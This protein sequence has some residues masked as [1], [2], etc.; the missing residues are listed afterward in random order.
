[1]KFGCNNFTYRV[2]VNIGKVKVCKI[3]KT[4]P[5]QKGYF[6]SGLTF[7]VKIILVINI[8]YSLLYSVNQ[9]SLAIE[10]RCA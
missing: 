10:K 1:M 2:A 7:C 9:Q 4:S 5:L 8:V 3:L 6:F